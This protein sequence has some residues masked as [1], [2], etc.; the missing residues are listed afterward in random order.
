MPPALNHTSKP[1]LGQAA[2]IILL[3]TA[4]AMVYFTPLPVPYSPQMQAQAS[5]LFGSRERRSRQ[6]RSFNKWTEMLDRYEGEIDA[7]PQCQGTKSCALRRWNQSL[8]AMRSLPRASQLQ[9]VNSLFNRV[10]YVQDAVNWGLP[11]YWS[12]PY[13]FHIK[14]GDCEDYA[15]SKYKALKALGWNQ[16]EMRIVVLMDHNLGIHHSVLAV[17]DGDEIYILDN[18]IKQVTSHRRIAHYEPIYSINEN[19]WWRHR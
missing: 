9:E 4:W 19:F 1:F 11:D 3:C 16:N 14:N 2:S 8:N 12:T 7:F 13:E 15:I 18:Q 5:E 6:L 10:R 17:Y